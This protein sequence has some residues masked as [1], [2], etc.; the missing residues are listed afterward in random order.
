MTPTTSNV[1]AAPASNAPIA[2]NGRTGGTGGTGVVARNGMDK[3][4]GVGGHTGVG[5]TSR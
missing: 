4:V 2:E 1:P 3:G 5:A